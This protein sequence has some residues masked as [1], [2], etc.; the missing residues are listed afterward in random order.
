MLAIQPL[1][2]NPK[3]EFLVTNCTPIKKS[4]TNG[5]RF[6]LTLLIDSPHA[7]FRGDLSDLF[8]GESPVDATKFVLQGEEFLVGHDIG[9]GVF[10]FAFL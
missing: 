5:L 10:H 6:L 7:R 2:P 9:V 1:Q 3:A 4:H 8:L